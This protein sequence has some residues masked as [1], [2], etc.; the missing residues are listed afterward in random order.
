MMSSGI[1]HCVGRWKLIDISE[2]LNASIIGTSE[3]L[4][5]FYQTTG[6]YV[7]E[8]HHLHTCCCENPKSPFHTHATFKNECVLIGLSSITELIFIGRKFLTGS[9]RENISSDL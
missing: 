9:F 4:V 3:M 8:D 7:T 2:V 6:C 5:N 1:F